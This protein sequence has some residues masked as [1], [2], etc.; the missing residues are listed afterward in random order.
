MSKISVENHT[1]QI[2]YSLNLIDNVT[3]TYMPIQSKNFITYLSMN[4]KW[5]VYMQPVKKMK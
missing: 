4:I 2:N 5:A 3:V 1:L